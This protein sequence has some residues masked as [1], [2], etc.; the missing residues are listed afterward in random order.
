MPIDCTALVLQVPGPFR[1]Q[2][3][4]L[5]KR[6]LDKNHSDHA[7]GLVEGASSRSHCES[8]RA[9]IRESSVVLAL[10]HE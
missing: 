5:R 1:A 6:T 4:E 9:A 3:S 8:V 2:R 10:H 7:R